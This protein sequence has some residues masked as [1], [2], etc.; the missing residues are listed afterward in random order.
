MQAHDVSTIVNAPEND[1]PECIQPLPRGYVP[2]GQIRVDEPV[3]V[4]SL[5]HYFISV[6][7]RFNV[8]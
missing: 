4:E 3:N 5:R 8:S 6:E 2:R 1:T 7:Q